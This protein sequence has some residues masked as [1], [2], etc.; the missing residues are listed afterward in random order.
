[1]IVSGIWWKRVEA[2]LTPVALAPLLLL[3]GCGVEQL[4]LGRPPAQAPPE[5]LPPARSRGDQADVSNGLAPLPTPQQ[6]LTAVP[7]GRPDPFAPLPQAAA[8]SPAVSNGSAATAAQAAS[9]GASGPGRP[10]PA[11]A[12]AGAGP[13]TRLTKPEGFQ[14]TGVIRSGGRV[15]ALV[16][17]GPLSGSLRLG[18]RGG[19]TTQLLPVGWELASIQFG[20]RTPND[21]PSITLRRAGQPLTIKLL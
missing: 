11:G 16:S 18:D 17:Y 8:P 5:A 14:L 10:A 9:T 6:V 21:P 4:L 19:R 2:C 13:A 15:E 12:A 1:M 3:G 7:F 20:G